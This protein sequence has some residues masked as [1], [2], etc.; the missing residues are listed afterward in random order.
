VLFEKSYDE[1]IAEA[2][3]ELKTNTRINRDSPGSKARALLEVISRK[4][5]ESYRTFDLNL[6]RPFVSGATGRFLDF[7]GEML[8]L[9][10]LGVV[11][12]GASVDAKS[13]RF[14]VESGTFGSINNSSNI[15]IP[16]NT[17]LSTQENGTGISYRVTTATTLLAASSST[18]VPIEA[19]VPGASSNVGGGALVFHSFTG[20][21]DVSNNTLK[22]TNDQGVFTGRDIESDTNFRFRITKSITGAEAANRSAILLAALS[23][24]G[25]AEIVFVPYAR[26]IGTYD[27]IIKSV[28]PLVTD[29]LIA[30]VQ[31]SVEAVS[32]Q[33]IIPKARKPVET[34]I[35][36]SVAV[37]YVSALSLSDRSTIEQ[38]IRNALTSYINGLD[39][40]EEFVIN[41]AV[42]RVLEVD[43]RIKDIGEP[44][45]PFA[46]ISIY[47]TT[48]LQDNKVKSTLLKNYVPTSDER[49]IIEPS[50]LTPITIATLV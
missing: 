19:V 21:T 29:S 18:Y 34:G 32:A 39:I 48:K 31:A 46:E 25:V 1:L 44:G 42:Q 41:E 40:S 38:R 47:K 2:L 26:G 9:R 8:G 37:R 15:T 30:A 50:V 23:V 36:F 28:T 7:I 43:E 16:A 20:Y 13:A 27:V 6:A 10:R 4:I 33:G 24:P 3:T 45:K 12:A 22:T 17:I 11:A 35:T 5:N 14:F 49:L